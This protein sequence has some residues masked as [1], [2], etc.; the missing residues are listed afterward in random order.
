MLQQIFDKL[1]VYDTA[2]LIGTI[3][4]LHLVP[5]NAGRLLRLE[6]YA[7]AAA[8]SHLEAAR[9][10]ITHAE[11][12]K[13]M[14]DDP[15]AGTMVHMAEDP[16]GNL[17]TESITFHGGG[18]IVF[19][20]I[21]NGT[22]YILRHLA[23]AIFLAAEPFPN[24]G[25][26]GR[27]GELLK[28][29]LCLSDT[30]A[31][32]A[33]YGRWAAVLESETEGITI[34]SAENLARLKHAVTFTDAELQ[35]ALG[36]RGGTVAALAPLIMDQTD[37]RLADWEMEKGPLLERP[38]LS[39]GDLLLVAVPGMMLWATIMAVLRMAVDHG[40][41]QALADKHTA[42]VWHSVRESL[43]LFHMRRRDCS[44]P[45]L[46]IPNARDAVFAIDV[47]KAM[48]VLLV[49]DPL[50]NLGQ[51]GT[52]GYLDR[53]TLCKDIQGRLCEVEKWLAERSCGT[54]NDISHLL[55][56]QGVGRDEV[57][58]FTETSRPVS[59]TL[60]LPA[61]ALEIISVQALGDPLALWKFTRAREWARA[62]SDIHVFDALDEY[63]FYVDHHHGYYVTDGRRPDGLSIQPG[64]GIGVRKKV[65]QER[66]WHAAPSY[67]GNGF[68]EVTKVYEKGNVP[69]Y[70]A[71]KD[72]G[73]RVALLVEGF[74]LPFW[75]LCA[76]SPREGSVSPQSCLQIADAIA[77]W[78]WQFKPVISHVTDMLAGEL[79]QVRVV[80]RLPAEQEWLASATGATLPAPVCQI[81]V[82]RDRGLVEVEVLPALGTALMSSDNEG[83]RQLVKHLLEGLRQLLPEERRDILGDVA[84]ASALDAYA[85]RGHKKKFFTLNLGH[86][87]ALHECP[88]LPRFREVQEA[89]RELVLDDLGEY[90]TGTKGMSPGPIP[91]GQ[92]DAAL[93][94][95]VGYL[96]RCLARLVASL[97]PVS[98]LETL[99]A[100]S[101]RMTRDW[102]FLRLTLPTRME[103]FRNEE[104][105]LQDLH[106][107][108]PAYS[109]LRLASRFL[110][111]YVAACPPS[112][113]RPMSLSVYDQSVALAAAIVDYG[114][115]GDLTHYKIEDLRWIILESGRLGWNRER[116]DRTRGEF[117]KTHAVGQMYRARE[118][119]V[120]HWG[121][122]GRRG[123]QLEREVDAATE[124]EFGVPLSDIMDL[125]S[126]TMTLG[127]EEGA[128]VCVRLEDKL[129]Q[130]VACDLE[131]STDRAERVFRLLT[132]G[133][134]QD[135]L[136]PPP[137]FRREDVYPWRL[138]R[139]LSYIRRPFIIRHGSRGN[140][141][142][143]GFRHLVL[144]SRYWI[145]AL[146][147]GRVPARSRKLKRLVSKLHN[148][149]G[150][151]FNDEVADTLERFP[152]VVVRRRVKRIENLMVPGDIDVLVAIP[153]KRKLRIIECKD[154][155][156]ARMPHEIRSEL[157]KIFEGKRGKK[158]AVERLLC[159]RKWV[160]EHPNEVLNFLGCNDGGDWAVEALFV[161][162]T[163][164]MTPFLKDAPI[165][166]V[167]FAQIEEIL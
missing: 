160:R 72:V 91:Q 139:A 101:E 80:V 147:Y 49:T 167:P 35:A 66:D 96:Y 19:P 43:D 61:D 145:D 152:G 36:D 140:E 117:L 55:V 154:L 141:V 20:G 12:R 48:Y 52:G 30:V 70:G 16:C 88:E 10:R 144:A 24:A 3:A 165:R 14:A 73:K 148:I 64:W 59:P 164:M 103:C 23:K 15:L 1:C 132:L 118:S 120:H 21:T 123:T 161:T 34:P 98:V 54:L 51:Q 124:A 74:A 112:G 25:F 156:V 68:L 22:S 95:V 86:N 136:V 122:R 92:Q 134:R 162:D 159:R 94:E 26:A 111:E 17:L 114:A 85:P 2:D 50:D 56:L 115:L 149:R 5:Q 119:F 6:A 153:S 28:G 129:K 113:F 163:E 116:Y 130:Q 18:Y 81:D 41:V 31:R 27:T 99:I 58:A 87:P 71:L 133:P 104:E 127:L 67:E 83:E 60:A 106:Q 77:Y 11:L 151:D 121:A 157:L 46:H 33:G 63:G 90:L 102:E 78:L 37:C 9:P 128:A 135:F 79:Q 75:V 108:L 143:W 65:L 138:D 84:I 107:Q 32:R 8:S 62:R 142:L 57:Y 109:L 69:I 42:A 44:P 13:L 45:P 38:L 131:W 29:A 4:A 39:L 110:I 137:E 89:D 93:Q 146:L 47:D 97:S 105:V 40:V 166:F 76:Y 7:H 150:S 126:A 158:S 100:H 53:T 82:E 125:F 155:E